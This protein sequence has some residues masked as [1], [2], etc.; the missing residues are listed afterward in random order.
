MQLLLYIKNLF[1]KIIYKLFGRTRLLLILLGW[2][3]I[4]T[5]L[6]MYFRPKW[7][8]SKLTGHGFGIL[9]GY[10][11]IMALFA[12]SFLLSFGS[13][14]EG[15][16]SKIVMIVGIIAL[17]KAYFLLKKKLFKKVSSWTE[18]LS[19]KALK[20]YAVVQ[21]IIGVLMLIFQR[22]FFF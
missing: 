7:A 12:A 20:N 14:V 19:E 15:A 4:I 5:G 18:R 2:F 16:F 1:M 22:R 21:V 9:K 17:I 3:L 8:R 6:L 13:N 11:L 10:M